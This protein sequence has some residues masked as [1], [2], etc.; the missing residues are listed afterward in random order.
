VAVLRE[1]GWEDL[2]GLAET[3]DRQEREAP[4]RRAPKRYEPVTA[5]WI[6]AEVV[7]AD[8]HGEA[9]SAV[10]GEL[11]GRFRHRVAHTG[12]G[13]LDP[14]WREAVELL[15]GQG[16]AGLAT[17]AADVGRRQAEAAETSR[18]EARKRANRNYKAKLKAARHAEGRTRPGPRP[19][20]ST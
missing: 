17:L 8:M 1:R 18:R 6:V 20:A 19:R 3:A 9:T 15:R 12:Q 13:D 4:R 7:A 2:A 14:F 16:R 10:L 11:W 5:P